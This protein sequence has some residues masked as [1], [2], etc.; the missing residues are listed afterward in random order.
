MATSKTSIAAMRDELEQLVPACFEAN[1][2]LCK[3]D[4]IRAEWMLED[5]FGGPCSSADIR[6]IEKHAKLPLPPSYRAFL[7]SFG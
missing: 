1:R 3:L 2:E 5:D 7:A 4:G 6:A